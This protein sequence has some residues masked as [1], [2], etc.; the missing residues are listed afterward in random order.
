M[1]KKVAIYISSETYL[2]KYSLLLNNK[3]F[4][5]KF[6]IFLL[7]NNIESNHF[8][9]K[10]L[11]VINIGRNLFS[12]KNF[13]ETNV[14][15]D[16]IKFFIYL[17]EIFFYKRFVYKILDQL[18]IDI[19]LL[20]GDRELPPTPFIIN[21]FKKKRIP[22]V[23]FN[24]LIV[25]DDEE[26]L[27]KKRNN[28]NFRCGSLR[29]DKIINILV[30][31]IFKNYVALN[32]KSRILFTPGWKI[33][34]LAINKIIYKNPWVIGGSSNTFLSTIDNSTKLEFVKK[35]IPKERIFSVG[36]LEEDFV[37][38]SFQKRKIQNRIKKKCHERILLFSIPNDFEEN[39]CSWEEHCS[40]LEKL[41]R[42][43]LKFPFKIYYSLHPKSSKLLYQRDIKIL[44]KINF[45][46]ENISSC[47]C[48]FDAYICSLSSTLKWS[49][50]TGM[51]TLNINPHKI[52]IKSYCG[53]SIKDCHDFD[54]FEKKLSVIF[55]SL[56]KNPNY[57]EKSFKKRKYDFFD[58]NSGVRLVNKL[59]KL[60]NNKN[61]RNY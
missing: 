34:A 30:S 41:I 55:N 36:D 19:V 35:G 32:S 33:L 10:G 38:K 47:F 21:F 9:K 26:P 31:K 45:L 24:H 54:D 49:M 40:R 50:K 2:H 13:L 29:Q 51:K 12:E 39:F 3:E 56:K 20:P 53:P 15:G 8:K 4:K 61:Y 57:L 6:S 25:T 17:I 14:F 59:L 27:V 23:L 46:N 52:L 43:M 22:I 44:S 1:K 42:I 5:N 18:P 7:S 16:I 28:I 48:F 60:S 37:Y 58:G 11:E